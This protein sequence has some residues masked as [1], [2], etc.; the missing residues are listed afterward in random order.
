MIPGRAVTMVLPTKLYAEL[1]LLR[2]PTKMKAA[3][4]RQFG[5][6]ILVEDIPIPPVPADGVLLQVMA[7]G[8]C[9]SDWHG[10][11]GHDDD[12]HRHG[13]PFVPGHEVAGIICQVGPHVTQLQIGDRVAVPFILS[14]GACVAC[15]Q[16][17]RPTVCHHQEQPG[18]TQF[19]SMAEYL[20]IPRAERNLRIIPRGVSFVQAAALGCRFTTAYRALLQQGRLQPNETVAIFGCGG[21]GLSCIMLAKAQGAAQ[22]I[23]IDISSLALEK[24]KTL[25]ASHIIRV[26]RNDDDPTLILAAV[27]QLTDGRGGGVDLSVDAAGFKST[28]EA[29]VWCTRRAGRMVQV[30]LPIGGKIAPQIPMGRVVARELELIGSHGFAADDMPDLLRLVE[31]GQLDPGQLVEREVTLSEGAK[32][33][34]EMDHLDGNQSIGITMVTKFRDTT[35][36]KL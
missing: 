24:A 8:V 36:S 33:I 18:F 7:T 32:A 9:R 20:A 6:P 21:L 28:C 11:K 14:C 25:G 22:I 12:I 1:E 35:C 10:W 17:Q 15:Q 19:G 23:A 34:E 5:G 29:A 3:V 26:D 31:Q 13:L 16:Q 30:G 2:S 27:E 4:F